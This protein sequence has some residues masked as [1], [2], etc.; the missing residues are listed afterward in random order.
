[1]KNFIVWLLHRTRNHI[2]KTTAKVFSSLK[3]SPKLLSS[4]KFSPNSLK[5]TIGNIGAWYKQGIKDVPFLFFMIFTWYYFIALLITKIIFFLLGIPEE[6]W[7]MHLFTIS[8]VL[9]IFNYGLFIYLFFVCQYEKYQEEKMNMWDTL[10]S[11]NNIEIYQGYT[12]SRNSTGIKGPQGA[13][14][15][16][17]PSGIPGLPL[18]NVTNRPIPNSVDLPTRMK[19]VKVF[20]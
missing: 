12:T 15:L 14:G 6:I 13:Q 19:N 4:L 8:V 2:T 5:T 1:M 11:E 20:K 18:A 7:E 10:Q 3:S 16:I 17:G 9:A